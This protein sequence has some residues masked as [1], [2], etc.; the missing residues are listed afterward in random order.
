MSLGS[1]K[2]TWKAK[3]NGLPRRSRGRLARDDFGRTL[4]IREEKGGSGM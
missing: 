4:G 1:R 2:R 3:P